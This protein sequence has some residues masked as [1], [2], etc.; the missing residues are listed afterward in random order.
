MYF[1]VVEA[2]EDYDVI[3]VKSEDGKFYLHN[4]YVTEFRDGF[5]EVSEDVIFN[6]FY[7]PMADQ[8]GRAKLP[9]THFSSLEAIN[10]W[11]REARQEMWKKTQPPH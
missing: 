4:R 8:L 1:V 11:V 3:G 5:K 10:T 2:S 6:Q 9:G 7:H